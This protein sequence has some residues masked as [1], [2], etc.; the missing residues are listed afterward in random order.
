MSEKVLLDQ[1]LPRSAA[2][3]LRRAGIE[4]VHTGEIGM[5]T[6]DDASILQRAN[7]DGRM[8][9]TLD[10][11]F[12]KLMALAGATHPSVIRIRI[13]GLRGD[14]LAHLI[15]EVLQSCRDDLIRGALVSV[16]ERGIRIRRLP[17]ARPS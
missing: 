16:Q 11:D 6:A 7:D 15:Q 3:H 17:L 14:A 10:A 5:A 12:H 13:E 1:G 4:T 2:E 8:V 9:V